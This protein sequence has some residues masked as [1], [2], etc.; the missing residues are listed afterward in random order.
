MK[1]A[2]LDCF[3]GISGDMFL[4]AL[5]DAGL[6]QKYLIQELEKLNIHGYTLRIH[7][8]EKMGISA[9]K[10]DVNIEG[11]DHHGHEGHSHHLHRGLTEIKSLIS[12]S[13]LPEKVKGLAVTIFT[14]LGE[15]EAKVHGIPVDKIHFHEVGAVDSIV[16]IVGAAIGVEALGIE[17]FCASKLPKG[18]GMA[19]MAHG[20]FPV[21]GPATLELLKGIPLYDN[22][23]EKELVTPTGAAIL[24]TLCQEYGK[25]P[26]MTVEKIAYGAGGWDLDIPNVLRIFIGQETVGSG[27]QKGAMEEEILVLETNIDDMNP[28]IFGYL[29]EKIYEAGALEAHITPILM[30]KNRPA[31]LFTVLCKATQLEP[32]AHAIFRESTTLGIRY[33]PVARKALKRELV[34]VETPL[35]RIKMKLAKMDQKIVNLQPE[36]DHCKKIAEERKIPLKEVM[37]IAI[38]EGM[39]RYK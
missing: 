37:R 19:K 39:R 8:K 22:G 25:M 21:P 26:D 29:L 10:L 32:I 33:Y 9:T 20:S 38:E 23:I 6:D 13:T 3:A 14:R 34:E 11:G 35:G 24:S 7:Q 16:D 27:I 2:Y 5:L 4:G 30:K 36:Y 31:H 12:N 17:K 1:I 28:Q 18:G 15:A